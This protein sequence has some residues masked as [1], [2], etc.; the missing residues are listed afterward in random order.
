MMAFD[1]FPLIVGVFIVVVFLGWF[2]RRAAHTVDQAHVAV[3]TS[4]GKYKRIL[5]PGL[6]FINPITNKVSRVVPV[7]NQTRSLQFAAITQDQAAVHF[8]ATIIFTVKDHQE[9]TILDVAYRFVDDTSFEIAMVSAVE[10]SVREHVASRRQAEILGLRQEIVDHAKTALDDQLADWGYLLIDLTV[11]DISFDA[12]VMKSMSRVVAAKN[13]QTAAEFEGQALLIAR[14][15]EAEADGQALVIAA[16]REAE[17][18]RLRGQGIAQFRQALAE[19]F[20]VSAESLEDAGLSPDILAFSMWTETIRDMAIQGEG[21]TI[22]LDGGVEAMQDSMRRLQGFLAAPEKPRKRAPRTATPATHTPA[23]AAAAPAAA[24]ATS[25]EKPQQQQP[26]AGWYPDPQ[27]DVT[28]LRFWNG[29]TW[30]ERFR[31]VR[32]IAD[33]AKTLRRDVRRD[34]GL[35]DKP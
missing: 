7:Q 30:T 25:D 29:S 24:A 8:T 27:G 26:G 21:N 23:V 15:K 31:Q 5:E 13:A 33:Q 32:D 6:N 2:I 19:G 9:Q 16:E 4:F 34:L 3:V 22:F 28:R 11:N 20:S 10:A 1:L 17:A 12:E 14:T 18:A 35:D